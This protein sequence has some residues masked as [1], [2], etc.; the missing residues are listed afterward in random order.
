MAG[1]LEVLVR[2]AKEQKQ[3]LEKIPAW[4]FG[5]SSPWK[6]NLTGGELIS[7]G[8]DELY[9]LGIRVGEKFPDLFSEEYHP[10][11]YSIKTTQV[12]RFSSYFF[13]LVSYFFIFG[14]SM[15]IVIL[16]LLA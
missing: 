14:Q 10:D 11:V 5:W 8:E 16:P 7:E 12:H 2:D 4:L 15:T 9:H 13:I 6:G 3:S 1:H